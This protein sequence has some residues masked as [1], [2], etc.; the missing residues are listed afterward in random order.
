MNLT[1]DM[2]AEVNH[3]GFTLVWTGGTNGWKLVEVA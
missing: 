3:A 1:E 2:T